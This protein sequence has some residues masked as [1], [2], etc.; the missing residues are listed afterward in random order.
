MGR[1]RNRE[2]N[3][4]FLEAIVYYCVL[5]NREPSFFFWGGGGGGG[6]SPA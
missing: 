5:A 6:H 4:S 3:Y 2:L 1:K